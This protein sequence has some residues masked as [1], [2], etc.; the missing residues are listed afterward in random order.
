MR[1]LDWDSGR[2]LQQDLDAE[3]SLTID[4]PYEDGDILIDEGTPIMGIHDIEYDGEHYEVSV[5]I[6]RVLHTRAVS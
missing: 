4:D 3:F 1:T 5:E 2:I 6:K